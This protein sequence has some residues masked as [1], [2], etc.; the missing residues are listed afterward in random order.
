MVW[1]SALPADLRHRL[2]KERGA[3]PQDVVARLVA[4]GTQVEQVRGPMGAVVVRLAGDYLT[5]VQQAAGQRRWRAAVRKLVAATRYAADECALDGAWGEVELAQ[6]DY[7]STWD[8]EFLE[9]PG[10]WA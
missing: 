10:Y 2:A 5:V 9:P 6:R 4:L 7:E 3:V 1:W 8:L